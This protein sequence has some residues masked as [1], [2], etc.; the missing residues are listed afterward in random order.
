MFGHFRVFDPGDVY[1]GD[2]NSVTGGS[3]VADESDRI[4]EQQV[5]GKRRRHYAGSS[6]IVFASVAIVSAVVGSGLT[7]AF[8]RALVN[9]GY[10]S[11]PMSSVNSGSGP[12]IAGAV[13]STTLKKGT[14]ISTVTVSD[15]IVTAVKKATPS[16]VG[17]INLQD[18]P[19]ASM[20][21]PNLQQVAVGSGVIFSTR[22]Y[23]VTNNHVVAGANKVE[24]V[25]NQRQH[26]YARVVGTDPYTDLA[27]LKVPASDIKPSNVSEFGNSSALHAGQPAIAIGN[28]AG[29]AFA[30]SVTVGVISATQR[31]M[32]VQNVAN[33]Q[34]L[35]QET[36]LQTSAAINPGN[37]GGPLLNLQGQVI[38]INSSKIVA[39]GFSGMG[40]AIPSNE[41]KLIADELVATGHAFHAAIGI[42]GASLAALP[43]SLR[44]HVPVHSGVWVDQLDSAYAKT[45]GLQH[46][47]VIVA[48]NGVKVTGVSDL[49]IILMRYR[50]GQTVTI[51]F[52][53]GMKKSTAHLQL[54][55]LPTLHLPP[56]A[57]GRV[58][59]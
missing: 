30:D 23:I 55:N 42:E 54:S 32:P 33:G 49:Q 11:L 50:P 4:P 39:T 37:S 58:V 57:G 28:P 5:S 52:Y 9:G 12:Y 14:V 51:T 34:T 38:G 21:G 6:L 2:I 45:A 35:G 17:V 44:P 43:K 24:V 10:L 29:F 41:V 7:L 18:R 31:T 20:P 22:G 48:V 40:F 1:T 56:N 47:D 26:V 3:A 36:V 16:V 19:N 46:G 13:K 53:R 25:I 8:L 27:V 15:P 59:G